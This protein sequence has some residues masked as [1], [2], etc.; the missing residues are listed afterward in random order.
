MA[1]EQLTYIVACSIAASVLSVL[2]LI[3]AR[4]R[5]WLERVGIACAPILVALNSIILE[6]SKG[7]IA[8]WLRD[9]SLAWILLTVAVGV[10]AHAAL[11]GRK[12]RARS[13]V[14]SSLA[15]GAGDGGGTST[16]VI[17]DAA[18][19]SSSVSA[20]THLRGPHLAGLMGMP[21]RVLIS[22]VVAVLF[23]AYVRGAR[24]NL[25][26]VNTDPGRVD[27][28]AYLDYARKLRESN[29]SYV[30]DRNR[31]PGY[32][33]LQ[34][35][36]LNLEVD[37]SIAFLRGKQINLGLSVLLL[38]GL[39]PV[40]RQTVDRTGTAIVILIGAFT[41]FMFKAG[42]VQSE[43]LYYF[44]V[45][46]M[47]VSCVRFFRSCA[48]EDGILI[49]IVGGLAYLTKAS[50]LPGL[51][52]FVLI[53]VGYPTGRWLLRKGAGVPGLDHG[54]H[55]AMGGILALGFFLLTVLPY[56]RNSREVYGTWFYN[57]NSTFYMWYDS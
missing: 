14:S 11:R 2:L 19:E 52:A 13:S 24:A 32:P 30:G 56:I 55:Q 12:E 42:Y 40:I 10:A 54:L 41:V 1:P 43:L 47:F 25:Y 4:G 33:F 7:G 38:A 51:A 8:F 49:G 17:G 44:L 21:G 27:Q 39:W 28:S 50:A 53:A 45:T 57:V 36:M 15:C 9:F 6:G 35:V 22:C 37:P 18:R 29:Y 20:A 23:V 16:I 46:T 31:M 34:A 5:S 3:G 26:L 48:P